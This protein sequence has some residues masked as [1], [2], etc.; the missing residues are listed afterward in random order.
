MSMEAPAPTEA[1]QATEA[2]IVAP[3]AVPRAGLGVSRATAEGRYSTLSFIR[4]KLNDGRDRSMGVSA[5]KLIN[6][7]FIGADAELEKLTLFTA[8]TTDQQQNLR[9]VAAMLIML[10]LGVPG[11]SGA[12]DWLAENIKTLSEA[13]QDGE[14]SSEQITTV[15]GRMVKLSF[16]DI[17]GTKLIFLSVEM[18]G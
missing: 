10:D 6:L 1:P 7:E 3:T 8:P 13:V 14:S 2:P 11:W 4:N 15:D 16:L 9:A 5:D 17:G 12:S 18:E